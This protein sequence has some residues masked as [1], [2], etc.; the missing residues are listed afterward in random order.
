MH[1]MIFSF[2]CYKRNIFL[3]KEKNKS[4]YHRK[5]GFDMGFG[6]DYDKYKKHAPSNM[7]DLI[8]DE[9]DYE[10]A[11]EFDYVFDDDFEDFG[12]DNEFGI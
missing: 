12:E 2:F 5:G 6:F 11:D 4:E 7:R 3:F 10:Y 8:S 1:N 9:Y